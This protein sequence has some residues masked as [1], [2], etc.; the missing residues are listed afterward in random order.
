MEDLVRQYAV[1]VTLALVIGY[2]GRYIEPRSK[3]VHWFAATLRFEVPFTPAGG[4][5]P[6]IATIWTHTLSVQNLGWRAVR[7]VEII[8]RYRPQHFQLQ[9][10]LHFTEAT[11]PTGEHIIRIPSLARR[12]YTT[13]QIIS[14]GNQ[15]PD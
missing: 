10:A 1:P 12:E 4:N 7:D 13:I 6:Q 9:P 11:N 8:H 3:L 15:P 5:A 2:L 14:H